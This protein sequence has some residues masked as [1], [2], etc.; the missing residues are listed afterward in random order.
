[1]CS[2]LLSASWAVAVAKPHP[3][4]SE[5]LWHFQNGSEI[6]DQP[7][8]ECKLGFLLLHHTP[9]SPWIMGCEHQARNLPAPKGSC[10]SPSHEP[11]WVGFA[12]AEIP[13]PQRAAP[14][15]FATGGVESERTVF[16][17]CLVLLGSV[18][19]STDISGTRSSGQTCFKAEPLHQAKQ[20]KY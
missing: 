4:Y 16:T 19:S 2:S 3:I 6:Q 17:M 14:P 12:L 11:R 15:F 20:I 10:G 13:G 9:S 18:S 1:M 5:C 7:H 8:P